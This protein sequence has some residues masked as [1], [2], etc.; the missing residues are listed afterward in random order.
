MA[1]KTKGIIPFVLITFGVAWIPLAIQWGLGL[2]SPGP[3][4]T[5]L[6]Y[7]VFALVTLPTSFAPA[8]GAI[9]VRKWITREGFA[10]SGLRPNLRAGWRYY[11]FAVLYPVFVVPTTLILAFAAGA[12]LPD[13]TSLGAGSVLQMIVVA[14]VSTP[15]VWGEEFGWRG[16]LQ[17]RLLPERPLLAAVATGLVWAVWHYPMILLGYLFSGNPIALVLYPINMVLTSIIYGWL[18]LRS[19]SVWAASLAHAT[20]NTVINPILET[21]QPNIAWPLLWGGYRLSALAVLC[22]WLLLRA[23]SAQQAQSVTLRG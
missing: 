19:G 22:A 23:R 18:R 10:D 4:A 12:G 14:I 20:G 6:D 8:I 2:R 7:A 13:F 11:V 17:L 9:V 16:Y 5:F 15:V 21:L 1:P 3:T